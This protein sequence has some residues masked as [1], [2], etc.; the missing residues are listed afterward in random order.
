MADDTN[1]CCGGAKGK[2]DA[3][4]WGTS[5]AMASLVLLHLSGL[6]AGF[7]AAAAMAAAVFDIIAV[8]WWGLLLGI[9]AVGLLSQAPREFVIAALG[10]GG[11]ASG[12]LRAAAAGVM[13]DL[14]SHGI[15]LVAVKLYERGATLGQVA[16]FLIASPWNSLSLTFILAALIGVK[17]TLLFILS[18]ALI[19]VISGLIF[20][21]LVA[22]GVLAQNPHRRQIA[23]DFRFFADAKRRW[24]GARFDS[25]FW[26][27]VAR[28]GASE[29]R[30]ILR[31]IFLGV[32]IAAAVRAFA[33]LD[34]FQTWF[35]PTLAGLG[36]TL[37]AAT[38]IEV[39]SE[40]STP[41]AADLVNRGD[42]PGNGFAFLMAGA[43][44][45]YTEILSLR[46][47]TGSWKT[48]L[49]VPLLTVPQV[50]VLSWIFNQAGG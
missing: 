34:F 13:L 11:G 21:R 17:W 42:A 30:M 45:D 29:S 23:A 49:F 38:V 20:E 19:A 26:A 41:I 48:A 12:V 46:E 22:R 14:C 44:T 36:A 25:A 18:S 27:R 3:L 40:G 50:A 1:H 4:F 31:W 35:G 37:L 43:A 15:L 24:K 10:R 8:M 16:A 39:C 7:A 9:F 33:P 6:A 2:T 28:A 5:A 47:A 32:L